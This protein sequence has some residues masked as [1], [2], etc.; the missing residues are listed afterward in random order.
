MTQPS[1]VPASDPWS[2][3]RR[4][5]ARV[6]RS[7]ATV[8]IEGEPG[9]G[10]TR[11]ARDL[12]AAGRRAA[13]PYVAID[14]AAL[15]PTLIEAELFGHEEGAF[16]GASR[17]RAGRIRAAHGGTLVLEGI[18]R[19]P[20]ALQGKLLRA[21]QER[22]VEPL[23]AESPVAVDVR[24]VATSSADL[25]GEV[26]AGRFRE[27]LYWRVAVVRLR[28][29]PLRVRSAGLGP[30]VDELVAGLARRAGLPPR[31]LGEAARERLARHSWPGNVRELENALERVTV[32]AERDAGGQARPV[33]AEEL[34]FLGESTAGA[35]ERI[36]REAL[37]Q[38]VGLAELDAR[39]LEL[40]LEENRGNA[41]AAARALGL[42][43]RAFEYRWNRRAA[44]AG[45]GG[46]VSPLPWFLLVLILL[47]REDGPL[48]ELRSDDPVRARA[49]AAALLREHDPERRAT[50]VRALL[51]GF[52]TDDP[53]QRV[54]R[55]G[56]LARLAPAER[57]AELAALFADRDAGVRAALLPYFSRP[58]LGAAG[59]EPRVEALERAAR[60]DERPDLRHAARVALGALDREPSA[61]A[62]ARLAR[63]LPSAEAADAARELGTSA[64]GAVHVRALVEGAWGD[65]SGARGADRIDPALLAALL[66]LYGEVLADA[67]E[68]GDRA[69]DAAPL[70][71]S[72][73]HPESAVRAAA[74]QAFDRLIDRLVLLGEGPRALRL[75]ADLARV[76]VESHTVH[77]HRARLAL[78]LAH[79]PSAALESASALRGDLPAARAGA[80]LVLASGGDVAQARRWLARSL[81]LEALARLAQGE[82]DAAREGLE[83]AGDV[84]DAALAEVPAQART[85]LDDGGGQWAY[86]ERLEERALLEID[87]VLCELAAG[88]SARDPALLERARAA[89][90][91]SLE[92]QVRAA[93]LT[94]EALLGW[95]PLLESE[96]SPYR[97]LFAGRSLPGLDIARA[98]ELQ[99]ELG[100]VLASVAPRELPGFEPF[101]G[102]AP[103]LADPLQDPARRALL[104]EIQAARLEGL[105]QRID[106][107]HQR[108]ARRGGSGWEIPEG[109]LEAIESLELRRRWLQ[110]E[111]LGID[112]RGVDALLEQ[113]LPSGLALSLAGDLRSE[114]RGTEA[115]ALAGRFRDDLERTGI[116]NW[117]YY[118][119]VERI[120]RAELVIGSSFT[121]D[122]EP[123]RAEEAL[124]AASERLAGLERRLKENGVGDDDLAPFRGLRSSVLVSL[125]VNANVKQGR[126]EKA[127]EY[128][129]EAY[130]LRQDDFMRALLACYRARSGRAEEARDLLA[131]V[132][133]GPQT[134][135]N[136][137]CTYALLGESARSLEL[138]AIELQEN[139]AS[140]AARDRQREWARS[141][142]DLASLRGDPRFEALV[143]K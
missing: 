13:G 129:E 108:V 48:A 57:A 33:E 67:P 100:R 130:A 34:D 78:A 107:L 121:D 106:D 138:L 45:G 10:K 56:I 9:S 64:R 131:D 143:G 15:A 97:L 123:V 16:T 101:P 73:R 98:I 110:A 135:Y 50:W 40:A 2:A 60:A 28:V 137:A 96:L 109:D 79:D 8:L 11:A 23:G 76:G 39:L 30:L 111:L 124:R 31:T 82:V 140:E 133:P 128:Y 92:I 53:A 52:A 21:L 84:L 81:V 26:A 29:P 89:H 119:G 61:A 32:L 3:F 14:L 112:E 139:H 91:L 42:S 44:P 66:P 1:D 12:H 4:D 62:L 27:D 58:D 141:D 5:L 19:L 43:R 75:L 36:A 134:W 77:T 7:D 99:A 68:G 49:A 127:L 80:G 87:R 46:R 59:L 51:D 114:G 20:P 55:A 125:A 113:R 103:E 90:R 94:G 65:P 54:R 115:R 126:P 95:D 38:G 17:A 85:G 18:E 104:E 88:A 63:E 41:S 72:L 102:L 22:S 35:A 120:V 86:A 37:A 24:L 83:R 122:D 142:P 118:L 116:S 25:A 132:R 69:R 6:A 74:A 117:W 136:L 71:A 93:R 47:G 70:I 105:G